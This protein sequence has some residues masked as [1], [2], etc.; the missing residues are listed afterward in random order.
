[1]TTV[2]DTH[3]EPADEIELP[4]V[5]Q[6]TFRPDLIRQAVLAAQANRKQDYGADE[7]AGMRTPAES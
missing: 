6:T 7:F 2:Y 1:M 4:D 3:G 5:F